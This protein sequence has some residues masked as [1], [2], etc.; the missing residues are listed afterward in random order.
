MPWKRQQP[1]THPGCGKLSDSSR[2]EEHRQ[3]ATRAYEKKRGSAAQRGYGRKWQDASRLY[4]IAHPW[5]AKCNGLAS[6]VDHKIPHRGDIKLFWD[7]GNWQS[8]C[9]EC[10]SRKTATEDGRWEMLISRSML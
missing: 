5:C 3:Q 8:L 7:R 2:C 1:C 6:E 9:H 4:L 10:H